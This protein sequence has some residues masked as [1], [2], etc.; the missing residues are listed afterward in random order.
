VIPLQK[1]LITRFTVIMFPMSKLQELNDK[2]VAIVPSVFTKE[3]C[4]TIKQAAYETSDSDIAAAGYPHVPSEQA[5][6]KK[7]LIFFPALANQTLNKFRTSSRLSGIVKEILGDNVKQIN[8]QIYFREPDD[9][10]TFAWHRDTIFREKSQ[11][12]NTVATNYLQTII[13]VDDITE[14]NGAVEFIEGSHKWKTFDAP[15]NLRKF[16]RGGLQGKKYLASA[17]D[18]LL[19]SVMV[20][21]GSEANTSELPRMTYMNGFC[22]SES[23]IDYPDYL[24]DGAVV[25]DIDPK[26]IP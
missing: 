4:E 13:V 6:N 12:A 10:D 22:K 11:F 3:E 7:S 17:G 5:Y 20:V 15:Q 16:N 26:R 21:H 25:V 18:V 19:W 1:T 24:V 9:I 8:N 14:D 2:G 23:V